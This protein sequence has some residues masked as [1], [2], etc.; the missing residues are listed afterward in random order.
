MT[1]YYQIHAR[2]YFERTVFINPASFLRP[3]VRFLDPGMSVLDVGCGSG[4]DLLWLK[5]LGFLTTGLERSEGMARFAR[6]YSGCDV[7]PGD[8][9]TFDFSKFS[10]DAILASGAFVHVP[11]G[12]LVHTIS[13]VKQ[14]L[15]PGGVF[16]VS[17]KHG[18]GMQTDS[19]GRQFY[20]WRTATSGPF[21]SK[22]K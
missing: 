17:L 9:E 5:Q 6:D 1:D 20:F 19:F 15:T 13:N 12:R 8:F 18:D 7:I 16:C 10:V 3:F 4:R 14:A 22:C 21:L 11:H 2:E